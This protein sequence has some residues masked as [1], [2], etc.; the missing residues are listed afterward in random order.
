MALSYDM[1]G[2]LVLNRVLVPNH[3]GHPVEHFNFHCRKQ[4]DHHVDCNF[5]DLEV[6][7]RYN[8]TS[9]FNFIT[10]RLSISN[11]SNPLEIRIRGLIGRCQCLICCQILDR[12]SW[13][14][15]LTCL[16]PNCVSWAACNKNLIFLS[17]EKS[18]SVFGY[19]CTRDSF[20]FDIVCLEFY[21]S[22]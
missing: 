16:I 10:S 18:G 8:Q 15:L 22:A 1:I 2:A 14:T 11:N 9:E 4:L 19:I 5:F 12:N 21:P 7:P 20:L 3:W 17:R 6:G 13:G